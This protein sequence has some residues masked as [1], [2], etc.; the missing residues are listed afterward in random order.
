LLLGRAPS[1]LADEAGVLRPLPMALERATALAAAERLL[2]GGERRLRALLAE[3]GV[4]AL[5]RTAWT[6]EDPAGLTLRDIDERAD[7]A[8]QRQGSDLAIGALREEEPGP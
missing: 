8:W 2:A 6:A 4:E 5:P 7:L 1:A 3:L